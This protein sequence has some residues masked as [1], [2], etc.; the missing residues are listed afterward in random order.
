MLY[1]PLGA[2]GLRISAIGLGGHWPTADGRR[3][4][5]G[6]EEDE[7]PA[8]VVSN[9]GEVVSAC[10]DAGINYVDITTAA[11]C[12]A[13]GRVLEGRRERVVLGADDYQWS[14]RNPDAL[15]VADLIANVERCLT[16][17]RTDYIDLWRVISEVHGANSDE[18]LRVVI[19]AA[20]RLRQAGKIRH[21]GLSAHHPGWIA[22]AIQQFDAFQVVLM[23]V[24]PGGRMANTAPAHPNAHN[25]FATAAE[26]SVGTIGIKPFAGGLLF[27]SADRATAWSQTHDHLARTVLRHLLFDRPNI[28]CIVPGFSSVAQVRTALDA[29]EAPGLSPEEDAWLGE[30]V[31]SRLGHLPREDAWLSDWQT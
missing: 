25:P 10:L 8:E 12:L 4:H 27:R 18:D 5:D 17:L 6:V 31:R 14:A 9:R 16:R 19:E 20:D 29:L 7:V 13:Y 22:R 23:P 26:R 2:T 21:L 15:R 30:Q 24:M 11:E 28:A 1:R 3:Y